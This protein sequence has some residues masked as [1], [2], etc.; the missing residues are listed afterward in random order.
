M[1][2]ILDVFYLVVFFLLMYVLKSVHFFFLMYQTDSWEDTKDDAGNTL[3]IGKLEY[4]QNMARSRV[5]FGTKF[6]QGMLSLLFFLL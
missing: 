1:S 3:H 4:K 5:L 2:L 6:S